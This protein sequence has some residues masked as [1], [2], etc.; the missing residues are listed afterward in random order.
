MSDSDM[1]KRIASRM[2]GGD[3]RDKTAG[4]VR[5]IK[6]KGD[7]RRRIPEDFEYQSTHLKS[8]SHVLWSLSCALGHLVSGH[9]DF[10]KMKAVSMSPDGMLGGK[11]YIQ[12]I[13][14]MRSGLMNSIETISAVIDTLHDEVTAEHW[15][16]GRVEMDPDDSAEVDEMLEDA[17]EI[18]ENPDEF[19]EQEYQE[20]I[21]DDVS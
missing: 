19:A 9:T 5:F 17:E 4:E 8:L 18:R 14:D 7:V 12:E 3:G 13:K 16:K 11:G 20:E 2:M 1:A 21:T 10:T 15:E 6:D